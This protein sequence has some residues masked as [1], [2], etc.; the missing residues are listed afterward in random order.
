[1]G[2]SGAGKST[3]LDVLAGRKN[4]GVIEGELYFNGKPRTKAVTKCSA[5][6]MQDNVHIGVLTVRQTLMYAASLRMGIKYSDSVKVKR[7]FQFASSLS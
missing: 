2:A 3:L 6:V 4:A 5:Y 7:Y 1:M